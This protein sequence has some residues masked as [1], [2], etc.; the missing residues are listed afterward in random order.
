MGRGSRQLV[1][2]CHSQDLVDDFDRVYI[3]ANAVMMLVDVVGGHL[4]V[5]IRRVA[6]RVLIVALWTAFEDGNGWLRW[7]MA[8]FGLIVRRRR[9]V[10]VALGWDG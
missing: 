6:V 10:V 2:Q 7:S 8:V 3:V 1:I 5:P 4:I 9:I